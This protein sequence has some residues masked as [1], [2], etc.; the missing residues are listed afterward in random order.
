MT[1]EQQQ[2]TLAG[3]CAGA[4]ANGEPCYGVAGYCE[5]HADDAGGTAYP[6]HHDDAGRQG[7]IDTLDAASAAAQAGDGRAVAAYL[8]AAAGL[9]RKQDKDLVQRLDNGLAWLKAH[10]ATPPAEQPAPA[11]APA[12]PRHCDEGMHYWIAREDAKPDE[13]GA[14][15]A[16]CDAVGDA[17]MAELNHLSMY[18]S[19]D[20]IA[21]RQA[22]RWHR[23]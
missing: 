12:T 16:K 14:Y 10:L 13:A 18:G 17:V 23:V 8:S 22:A 9:V 11:P 7:A 1:Y 6:G 20:A 2:Y 19:D 21:A 3:Q 5:W 4:G 15:C